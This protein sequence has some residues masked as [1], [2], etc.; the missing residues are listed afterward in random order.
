MAQLAQ[1]FVKS[2]VGLARN[3]FFGGQ[4]GHLSHAR[5]KMDLLVAWRIP[6]KFWVASQPGHQLRFLWPLAPG[7]L[8]V[9]YF[10]E[11]TLA[12]PLS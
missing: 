4:P 12:I 11:A 2:T 1:G 3:L 10:K 6:A 5:G 8:F 9:P 7:P